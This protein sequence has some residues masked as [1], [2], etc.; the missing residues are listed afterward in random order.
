MLVGIDA[1][2]KLQA[3]EEADHFPRT[4]Q[5]IV[6]VRQ[7]R[8]VYSL[9]KL[10]LQGLLDLYQAIMDQCSGFIRQQMKLGTGAGRKQQLRYCSSLECR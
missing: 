2:E 1:G 8:L 4:R 9:L 5:A 3:E 10:L 6:V 7:Y